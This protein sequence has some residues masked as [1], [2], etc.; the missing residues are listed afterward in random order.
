MAQLE[1]ALITVPMDAKAFANRGDTA[2]TWLG[3]AGFLVNCR[4]TII[5]IDPVLSLSPDQ[6][7]CSE[8]GLKLKIALPILADQLPRVDYVLYTHS[9]SD[10][11]GPLTALVLAQ[12]GAKFFGTYR[13]YHALTQLGVSP[14][15][16]FVCR[17]EEPVQLG[18]ITVDV[19]PADHPWQLKDL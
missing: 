19:T 17:E 11:L 14:V 12:K 7:G 18:G 5:L 9:D 6:E 1:N 16:A 10:H 13:V 15:Q 8:V 2:V 4:G 3:G